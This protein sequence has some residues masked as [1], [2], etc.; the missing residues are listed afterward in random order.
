MHIASVGMDL[1]KITF[2]L[3]ALGERSKGLS[4]SKGHK[5]NTSEVK[6]PLD[7]MNALAIAKTR[8]M[9]IP[10]LNACQSE[11]NAPL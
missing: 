7:K 6:T 11:G 10:R 4:A 9:T 2:H 3:V 1:G 5:P 8:P